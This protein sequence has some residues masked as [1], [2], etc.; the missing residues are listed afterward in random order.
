MIDSTVVGD[1]MR[2]LLIS[3]SLVA[4]M[5][6]LVANAAETVAYSYDARGRLIKVIRSG[7]A[8]SNS[9]VTT[10][11]THDKANNRKQFVTINSPNSP[12]APPPPPPSSNQPPVANPDNAGSMQI[13]KT[14]NVVVTANDTDPEG[15]VPLAVTAASGNGSM[16]ATVFNGTTIQIIS[17]TDTGS[18]SANYTVSDSLGASSTGTVTVNVSGGTCS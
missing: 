10:D 13:C 6:P 2:S 12:I 17:S 7:S 9:N 18:Q 5:V 4:L 14:K 8:Q 16:G 11:Y 15:N 1:S 3:V